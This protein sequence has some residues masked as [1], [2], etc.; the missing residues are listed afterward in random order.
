MRVN[1]R[2]GLIHAI[3]WCISFLILY[4]I[5]T[6]DYSGGVSDVI[7]TALFH[8]SLFVVVYLN[9]FALGYLINRFWYFYL[10]IFIAL[11]IVGVGLHFLIF[12]VLSD[13]VVPGYYFI[14]YYSVGEITQFTVVYLLLSGLLIM[15]FNWFNLQTKQAKLKAENEAVRLAQLKAQVQPHFLINSLNNIYSL[16]GSSN[17]AMKNYLVKLADALRYMVYETEEEKVLLK[18]ELDYLKNYIAL[19]KLR[20]EK[21]LDLNISEDGDFEGYMIAPL[22][23]LPFIENCFKHCQRDSPEIKISFKIDKD[24]F[25]LKT[26]N[27]IETRN[28]NKSG[29][30]LDNV[31]ARLNLIYP[32]KHYLE[33]IR[34]PNR[35]RVELKVN[36]S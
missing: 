7:Y 29:V 5:F 31:K 19:E 26:S 12:E 18:S 1:L 28:D 20:L 8:I 36:L 27:N 10:I 22:I 33:I 4:R 15:S 21:N 11:C 17:D 9:I 13:I 25:E 16:G 34:S 24:I 32:E 3:F 30:G 2:S 14:A 6:R 23:L 35:Y